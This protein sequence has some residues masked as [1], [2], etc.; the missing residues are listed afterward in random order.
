MVLG[1]D[2]SGQPVVED[3]AGAQSA[4]AATL[5]AEVLKHGERDPTWVRTKI[6]S[7]SK[8]LGIRY[9]LIHIDPDAQPD[10]HDNA[11]QILERAYLPMALP[12]AGDTS[13]PAARVI[14]LW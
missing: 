4:A 10:M 12:D 7:A 13:T 11:I 1:K 14:K 5:W 2:I 3:L 6:T 8:R 9:V